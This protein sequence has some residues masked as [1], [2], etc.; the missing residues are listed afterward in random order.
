MDERSK[1]RGRLIAGLVVMVL[2]IFL[3]DG[4]V[5]IVAAVGGALIAVS[6]RQQMRRLP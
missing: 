5:E 6:A 3:F 1:L 4:L 2:G